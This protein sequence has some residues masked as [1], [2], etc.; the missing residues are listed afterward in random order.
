MGVRAC[1]RCGSP[2]GTRR[3][4][5]NHLD[6]RWPAHVRSSLVMAVYGLTAL[7]V[8]TASG[9][10][11]E[12]YSITN[13]TTIVAKSSSNQRTSSNSS[14]PC[15][16]LMAGS[17]VAIARSFALGCETVDRHNGRLHHS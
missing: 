11:V 5:C 15:G 10:A 2:V 14:T 12:E 6:A 13:A 9:I 3:N 8:L 16:G 7:I 1:M 17:S 4:E